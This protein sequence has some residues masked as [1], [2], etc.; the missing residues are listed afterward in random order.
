[1]RPWWPSCH[2]TSA[3]S[4]SAALPAE[5]SV[6]TSSVAGFTDLKLSPVKIAFL[7][8]LVAQ[9][10]AWLLM[11]PTGIVPVAGTNRL[12]RI[13]RLSDAFKVRLD[14]PD[15]F[16]LWTLACGHEVP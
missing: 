8:V 3:R 5:T 14:R 12:D 1:M 9:T 11:H 15:W 10:L 16:E 7:T 4:T 13:A 2:L 6:S